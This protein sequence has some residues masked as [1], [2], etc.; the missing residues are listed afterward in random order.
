MGIIRQQYFHML[1]RKV[2]GLFKRKSFFDERINA[3]IREEELHER[4][5][6]HQ[7]MLDNMHPMHRRIYEFREQVRSEYKK[8]NTIMYFFMSFNEFGKVVFVITQVS[9]WI[10]TIAFLLMFTKIQPTIWFTTSFIVMMVGIIL[11]QFTKLKK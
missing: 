2:K 9:S 7:N 11:L 4:E 8:N 5:I 3:M 6:Y 10:F 1:L